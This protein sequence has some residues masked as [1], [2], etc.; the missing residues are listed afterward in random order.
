MVLLHGLTGNLLTRLLFAGAALVFW[1]LGWV[2]G[3]DAKVFM[4]L[5]LFDPHLA[6]AALAG[7]AL[8]SA[9]WPLVGQGHS[10]PGVTGFA[11][12]VFVLEIA[13]L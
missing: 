6:L 5:A 3:A 1:W 8:L 4:A 10:V 13:S 11:L 7:L 9:L 12:G 2:G